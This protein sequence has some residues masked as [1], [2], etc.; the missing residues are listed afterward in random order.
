MDHQHFMREVAGT[1]RCD[2]ARADAL[3]FVVFQEL[4]DR[5][6]SK[7]REDVA[8][9]LPRRLKQLWEEG[10]DPDR[11][12]SGVDREEFVGR[13]RQ[14]AQLPDDEEAERAVVAVFAALQRVLGSPSGGTEGEAWDVFSQLPK[15]LKT[16][17]L[18]A[19]E[20]VREWSAPG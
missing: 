12:V 3:T 8:A 11:P 5:L 16:L 1:L 20:R 19:A 15:G 14:R 17:W 10:T 9:Q 7:E 4:R 6:T 2:E 13:V 18:S